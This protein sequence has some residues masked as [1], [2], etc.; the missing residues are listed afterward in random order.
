MS[1][2]II[3]IP[4]FNEAATIGDLVRA[5]RAHSDVLWRK[6]FISRPRQP[7]IIVTGG[8]EQST[9]ARWTQENL[10]NR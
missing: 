8:G 9:T 7:A 3:V 4:V 10:R 5:A 1:D 6:E 2:H